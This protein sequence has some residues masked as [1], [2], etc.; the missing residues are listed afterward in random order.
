MIKMT[1]EVDG[2]PVV[3]D[4]PKIADMVFTEEFI[5]Q[6]LSAD[7]TLKTK[8]AAVVKILDGMIKVAIKQAAKLW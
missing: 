5:P 4:F 6:V 3:Y 1:I 8:E 2:Q 7:Q